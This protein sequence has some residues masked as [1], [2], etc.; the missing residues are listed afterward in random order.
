MTHEQ[1]LEEHGIKPEKNIRCIGFSE[2]KQKWYSWS[3]VLSSRVH[4]EFGIGDEV[5]TGDLTAKY[6]PIGFKAKTLT[7][8]KKMARAFTKSDYIMRCD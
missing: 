2:A 8:A 7:D 5:H 3:Y 4:C 6:L 1:W